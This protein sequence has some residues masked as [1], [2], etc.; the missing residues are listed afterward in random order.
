MPPL[1][2]FLA[3][4]LLQAPDS[5]AL[6]RATAYAARTDAQAVLVMHRGRVI[7]EAYMAGGSATR[8]QMLASGSKS[9]VGV[10]TLA[11]V[12]D[13]LVQLD[14][15]VSTY[16]TAWRSDPRK[17]R[18]TVR[19]LLSLESGVE[20]GNP[21]TGCGGP[22]STWNDAV[23]APTFAEPGTAFR[24]GPFPFVTMGAALEQR[25][26]NERFEHYLA[27]RILTP[28]GVTVEWR[29]RCADDNPQLAG[30]AAMTA[31]DWATF[32]EFI[33]RD[34]LHGSTRILP[35]GLVR[36]LF[37]P[38]GS[39]PSYGMS[40]WLV[41]ATLQAQPASEGRSDGAGGGRGRL[42]ERLQARRGAGGTANG[43][44]GN[45]AGTSAR[46]GAAGDVAM[47]SWMP[48]DLV[49]AAGMGKQRLYVIPS[50][51]L[52]VVRMGPVTGGLTFADVP[53]LEALLAPRVGAP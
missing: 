45:G 53:F 43:G 4:A 46:R 37:R 16:L 40:W 42:R 9:F 22:R 34:G 20:A 1:S 50:H 15:P 21:G 18:V 27:R 10:A 28:L 13:G 5:A 32:G 2:L 23:A 31:R 38:S 30:G 25:L 6:A 39:N 52:V 41:G 26:T 17:A 44:S 7:H 36:E 49:M 47:P 35:A 19:Q 14:Q 12:A 11:A 29:M 48:S 8:R 24:Y 33:R 51:E 3:A